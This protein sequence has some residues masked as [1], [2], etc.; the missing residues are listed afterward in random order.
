MLDASRSTSAIPSFAAS[1]PERSWVGYGFQM[2]LRL[3]L[4]DI[5]AVGEFARDVLHA[6]VCRGGRPSLDALRMP[7]VLGDG[8]VVAEQLGAACWPARA[9][10]TV[11]ASSARRRD[12]LPD[13]LGGGRAASRPEIP[14]MTT[15]AH[16]AA[17]K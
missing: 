4:D 10:S 15:C 5:D 7:L 13:A 16:R 12:R 17:G 14:M 8:E 3:V 6:T 11:I 9:P 2:R 1:L